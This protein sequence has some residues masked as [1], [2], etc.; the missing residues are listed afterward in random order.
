MYCGR[1]IGRDLHHLYR[2]NSGVIKDMGYCPNGCEQT[3]DGISDYC[4]YVNASVQ[5]FSI[6]AASLQKLKSHVGF[7]PNMHQRYD[8]I[9]QIGYGHLCE[10]YE[11][12]QGVPVPVNETFATTLLAEDLKEVSTCVCKFA[13]GKGLNDNQFGALV[14]YAYTSADG[15][16]DLQSKSFSNTTSPSGIFDDDSWGQ[17]LS[18]LWHLNSQTAAPC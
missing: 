9:W 5:G 3:A 15:C 18:N 14:D 8:Y 13:H 7:T 2:C 11:V 12:C 6:N 10:P 17:D 1:T 16:Q 4:R